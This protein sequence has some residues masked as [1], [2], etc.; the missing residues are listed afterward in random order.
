PAFSHRRGSLQNSA[1]GDQSEVSQKALLVACFHSCLF[2]SIRGCTAR[3]SCLYFPCVDGTLHACH[4]A[5]HEPKRFNPNQ[6]NWKAASSAPINSWISA[7]GKWPPV[8]R[9]PA[10]ATGN[11]I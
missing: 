4:I 10:F 5:R 11:Q 3:S 9:C 7:A 6:G 1:F 8:P 2:V